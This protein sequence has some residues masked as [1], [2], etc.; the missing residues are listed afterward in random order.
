MKRYFFKIL[1]IIAFLD[2]SG[3]AN[4]QIGDIKNLADGAAD[5]FSGCASSDIGTGCDAYYCC[6][7]GGFHFFD[8]LVEHHQEIMGMRDLDPCLLSLEI[9]PNSAYSFHYSIDSSRYYRYINYLPDIRAN[10]GVFS[11]Y[12]RYNILTEYINSLP[13]SYKTWDL[14]FMFNFVPDNGFKLSLGTGVYNE[15]Y[16]EKYYNEHYLSMQF[17]LFENKDFLNLDARVAVDYNTSLLPYLD[18]QIQ[19]KLRIMNIPHFY[20]YLTLGALYQDYYQKH[21]IWGLSAGLSFNIH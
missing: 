21:Q 1:I 11:A 8:F 20:T 18:V 15:N 12:F 13:D 2:F 19:Y 17:G 14:L 9:N 10:L 7:D 5:I 6:W 16:T 4:A 3:A